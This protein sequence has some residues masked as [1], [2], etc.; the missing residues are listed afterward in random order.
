MSTFSRQK[1]SFDDPY[2]VEEPIGTTL[3]RW[4]I[5]PFVS[6]YRWFID[7]SWVTK[8]VTTVAVSALTGIGIAQVEGKFFY[9]TAKDTGA[10]S[11]NV[12]SNN[13][14]FV[15][16]GMTSVSL[17]PFYASASQQPLIIPVVVHSSTPSPITGNTIYFGVLVGKPQIVNTL[18][19][20]PKLAFQATVISDPNEVKKIVAQQKHAFE[21]AQHNP[22]DIS[23]DFIAPYR[24]RNTWVTIFN[25]TIV[26]GKLRV[27]VESAVQPT[28]YENTQSCLA[29][30]VSAAINNAETIE[31][32]CG[33]NHQYDFLTAQNFANAFGEDLSKPKPK[34]S[35][36][37]WT[38]HYPTASV[39]PLAVAFTMLVISFNG[40]QRK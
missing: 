18:G 32:S 40:K 15:T 23:G 29:G 12:Q 34:S 30:S 7:Q 17:N 4:L 24:T 16:N 6:A 11:V 5:K 14:L 39:A 2:R 33:S 22:G 26:D 3:S 10:Q 13:L 37:N 9:R 27:D 35:V 20:D 28:N 38:G 36:L 25:P 19:N 31:F 8:T 1:F 21:S